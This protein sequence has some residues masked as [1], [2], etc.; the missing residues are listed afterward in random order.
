ARGAIRRSH[1]QGR[2]ARRPPGAGADQI[3][4]TDQPQDREGAR[5]HRAAH[6]ARPRR[7]GHRV[8]LGFRLLHLLATAHVHTAANRRNAAATRAAMQYGRAATIGSPLAG[9]P[10]MPSTSIWR[11][12]TDEHQFDAA[13]LETHASR[14]ALARGGA[15]GAWPAEEGDCRAAWDLA[16]DA[17]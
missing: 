4:A 10:R 3:R 1:P 8:V 17:L 6:V 16:A 9:T 12:I 7:R 5:H 11:T 14:R 2:Q 15:A 13:G